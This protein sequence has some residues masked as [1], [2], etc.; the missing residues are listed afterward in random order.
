MPHLAAVDYCHGSPAYSLELGAANDESRSL[1]DP[2]P[3]VLRVVAAIAARSL[4]WRQRCEK[5]ASIIVS[6]RRS[7]PGAIS[8]APT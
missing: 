1:V 8:I 7:I 3:K 4:P 6:G 2:D 5:W